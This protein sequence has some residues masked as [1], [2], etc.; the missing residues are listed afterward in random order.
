MS[1][2]P[3]MGRAKDRCGRLRAAL[4]LPVHQEGSPVS[5]SMKIKLFASLFALLRCNR[6]LDRFWF[7]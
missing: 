6:L 2:P 7:S 5:F 1:R 4:S 3:L